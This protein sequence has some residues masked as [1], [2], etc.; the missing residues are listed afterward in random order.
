MTETPSSP[1]DPSKN[2]QGLKSLIVKG[3]VGAISLAGVTA[4]PIV[5]KQHLE[6]TPVASPS[7]AQIAPAQMV[8][9]QVQPTAT[10]QSE[11]AQP[12]KELDGKDS[13]KK[14]RSKN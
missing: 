14:G 5:V 2:D 6:P 4:I 10:S 13:K 3:L 9:A 12:D 7:P 11:Q 1:S 8:P